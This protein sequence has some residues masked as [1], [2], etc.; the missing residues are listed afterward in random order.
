MLLLLGLSVPDRRRRGRRVLLLLRRGGVALLGRTVPAVAAC[1]TRSISSRRWERRGSEGE[2]R[3][4]PGVLRLL[5]VPTAGERALLLLLLAVRR[6]VAVAL[7][8]LRLR[9]RGP[10]GDGVRGR[11]ARVRRVGGCVTR[12]RTRRSARVGERRR[13]RASRRRSRLMAAR[14]LGDG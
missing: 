6:V 3:C 12:P 13:T 11:S 8:L 9:A 14:A 7:L 5:A 2:R 4:A 1:R 10:R